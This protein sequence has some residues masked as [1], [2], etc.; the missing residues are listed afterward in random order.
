MLSLIVPAFNEE[1]NLEHLY[2]AVADTLDSSRQCAWEIV[3]IDDNSRDR[4]PAVIA[5]LAAKDR[6]VRGVR[7]SRNTGAHNAIL[8]GMHH[9]RGDKAAILAAD[10]QDRPEVL[11]TM[12]DRIDS[13]YHVVWAVREQREGIRFMDSLFSRLFHATMQRILKRSDIP[14]AGADFF[15]IDKQVVDLLRRL[16]EVNVNVFA[17]IQWAGFRQTTINYAKQARQRGKSGWSLSKKI[18]LFIDSIVGFSY[19]P[20]RLF[21]VVGSTIAIVGFI[22]ALIVVVNF[23]LGRPAEGWSSTMVAV[24]VIGGANLVGMGVLGEYIWRALDEIRGRPAFIVESTFGEADGEARDA[25]LLSN[26]NTLRTVN[27]AR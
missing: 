7:L 22:Y 9:A 24:L 15:M 18:K 21:S 25:A 10:L 20:I 14:A 2:N 5:E 17:L 16:T 12:I 23:F 11:L 19:F 26:G 1:A 3:F 4:T 8:C 6:R 27:T 13:G